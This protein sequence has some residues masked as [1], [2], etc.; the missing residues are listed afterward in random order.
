MDV[1]IDFGISNIDAVAQVGG[2]LHCWT[3]PTDGAPT[4]ELVRAIIAHG[5]LDP[6][7][8]RRLAVTG[9][10]H[11]ELPERMGDCQVVGVGEVPAIGRG[12]QALVRLAGGDEAVPALVVSAGSGTAVVSARDGQYAHVT[13]SAV[14]GGTLLGL[15]RLLVGTVD[16]GEIDALAR[17]GD[18]NGADL[19][20]GDVVGG[21]IGRLP[22]SAT[23]VNFGRLSR[24]PADVRR[25]DL[26]AALVTLV[27]QVIAVTAINAARAQRLDR[28][29]VIGHLTDMP[30]VRAVLGLVGD[31][32]GMRLTLPANAGYGTA[33][34]AL[35][36]LEAV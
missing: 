14:G 34:G 18:A 20:L 19:S 13:G 4:P 12:G 27:G 31:W 24:H 36:S 1:A 5:G 26:A 7:G 2:A 22:A 6:A 11:Q 15:A 16:P 3:Q 10:R 23:A 9:G 28:V 8:L 30:S 35:S 29:V 25:E 21:P 33:L 17:A 32:Y